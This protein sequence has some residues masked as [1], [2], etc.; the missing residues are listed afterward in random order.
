MMRVVNMKTEHG[1]G[2]ACS[3]LY[4]TVLRTVYIKLLYP[5]RISALKYINTSTHINRR[6]LSIF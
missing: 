1:A 6:E 5:L 3:Y 4:R 2:V